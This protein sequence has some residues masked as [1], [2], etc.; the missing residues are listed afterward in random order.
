M[1]QEASFL[2]QDASFFAH[3]ASFLAQLASFVPAS[4]ALAAAGL[5]FLAL[6]SFLPQV[7]AP[8]LLSVGAAAQA[9][10]AMAAAASVA[11]VFKFMVV[12]SGW[13]VQ[14]SVHG[15]SVGPGGRFLTTILKKSSTNSSRGRSMNTR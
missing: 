10:E 5:P 7:P 13:S 8:H 12:S 11:R 6:V 14:H 4:L 9:D 3:P 1:L 2:A 15:D